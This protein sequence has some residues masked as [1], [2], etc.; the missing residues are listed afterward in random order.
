MAERKPSRRAAASRGVAADSLAAVPGRRT[1]PRRE[2]AG[3]DVAPVLIFLL[4]AAIRL[5]VVAQLRDTPFFSHPVIDEKTYDE[6]ARSLLHGDWTPRLVFWQ[7]PLYAYFL[8]LVYKVTGGGYVAARAATALLGALGCSLTFV[9][10]ARL[11]PRTAAWGG[12][13][14]AAVCGPL[15]L[16]DTQLL[17]ATLATVL[18]LATML[19][20]H[21]AQ[22]RG[23]MPRLALGGIT[24][25]L[26]AITRGEA[27]L[28]LPL[29]AGWALKYA[30]PQRDRNH[31]LVC[32][33]VLLAGALTPVAAATL[34]N[35]VQGGE[36]VVVSSNGGINFYIGNNPNY[37]QTVGIRPGEEWERLTREPVA[38]GI[39]SAAGQSAYFYSRGVSFAVRETRAWAAL[40]GRKAM[41]ALNA[42]EIQ[43][44][45]NPYSYR[46]ASWV[47][48]AL[49]WESPLGFPFGLLGPFAA[50]GVTLLLLAW[51]RLAL[52]HLVLIGQAAALLL[53]FVT[54][55]YRVPML[56]LLCLAAAYA[57]T[58][59]VRRVR[60]REWGRFRT[61]MIV[62]VI[63]ALVVNVP[64]APAQSQ[65]ERAE[66]VY[67]R[68]FAAN[69][70][71]DLDAALAA[72]REAERLDPHYAKA[73]FFAGYVLAAQ[74]DTAGARVAYQRALAL[75]PDYAEAHQGLGNLLASQGQYDA[76]A[77]EMRQATRLKSPFADAHYYLAAVLSRQ[78]KL[79]E[80]EAELRIA[81]AQ[82][83]LYAAAWISLGT[84]QRQ[85]GDAAA[86]AASFTAAVKAGPGQ[87]TAHA[88]LADALQALGRR[89]EAAAEAREALRLDPG[90][91]L[92]HRV[93]LQSQ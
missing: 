67:Y 26:V 42:R 81:V 4:A 15:V 43:R 27:L 29:L 55:R 38:K 71:G 91:P 41:L 11:L 22:R 49:L 57:V 6:W 76:A 86:A 80:A 85:R 68:G 5:L 66:E 65:R 63:A 1:P 60:H 36:W 53:F 3:F 83:P 62:W 32:A 20:L 9:L 88:R 40:L 59:L 52:L 72:A 7:P 48:R 87:A 69:E 73:A 56:P 2:S 75:A 23:S 44:D 78:N 34:Y 35:R 64:Q 51:R 37:D 21:E 12:A 8:A 58:W 14:A 13:L 24:L 77:A 31:R 47:L 33:A 89:A 10:G 17:N 84:L 46:D 79:A 45:L 25:G 19:Q 28:L 93:L 54:S 90:D 18:L 92:A 70:A 61:G 30:Q 82:Q 74:R 50:L 39:T 16:A